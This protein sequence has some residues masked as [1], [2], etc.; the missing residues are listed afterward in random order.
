MPEDQNDDEKQLL[1]RWLQ[2]AI[3]ESKR[4]IPAIAKEADV[5]A[6]SIYRTLDEK[7]PQVLS[8]RS[9]MRVAQALG[10]PPPTTS[11]PAGFD[12]PEALE[13]DATGTENLFSLEAGHGY[14]IINSRALELA[15][16]LPG[17][18]VCVDLNTTPKHGDIVCAQL[19][20]WERS[21]AETVLRCYEPPYLTA[22]SLEKKPSY[23]PV[24]IEN[25]NV[26]VRGTVIK[27]VR[28]RSPS[29]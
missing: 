27:L 7:T 13:Y 29:S 2:A 22:A 17:D 15:G 20:N 12:E 26:M 9:L 14:W 24:L 5:A 10:V 8:G 6:S 11:A 28:Q 3:T 1:R 4:S 18:I 16:V 23:A 19:Y 25:N 21:T